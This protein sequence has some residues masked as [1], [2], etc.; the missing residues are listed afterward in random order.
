MRW[1]LF[2]CMG[3]ALLLAGCSHE[4]RAGPDTYRLSGTLTE[5]FDSDDETD[6]DQR[7]GQRGAQVVIRESSPPQF[8]IEPLET[9]QCENLALELGQAD[10]V[11]QVG[12]CTVL[13]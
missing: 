5:D 9:S 7:A 13:P 12:E 2:A 3:A 10:Y 4:D 8:D 11:Q 1:L 6:L